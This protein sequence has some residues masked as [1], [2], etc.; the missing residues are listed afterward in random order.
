[1]DAYNGRTEG[2]WEDMN[3]QFCLFKMLFK[4]ILGGIKPKFVLGKNDLF[5]LAHFI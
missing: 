4:N 1:M 3:C 5:V 2:S